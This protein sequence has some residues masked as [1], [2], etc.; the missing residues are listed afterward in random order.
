MIASGTR[1]AESARFHAPGSKQRDDAV[2]AAGTHKKLHPTR[3][4]DPHP[5]GIV[6]YVEQ[7]VAVGERDRGDDLR[8]KVKLVIGE[9]RRFGAAEVSCDPRRIGPRHDVLLP[10]SARIPPQMV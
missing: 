7:D 8:E 1:R 2:G 9:Q 6:S 4:D 10:W 5:F 3:L